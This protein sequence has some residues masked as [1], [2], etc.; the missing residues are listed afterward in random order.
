MPLIKGTGPLRAAGSNRDHGLESTVARGHVMAALFGDEDKSHCFGRYRLR[1]LLGRGAHGQVFEAFDPEL[2]RRVA[3]KIVRGDDADDADQLRAGRI[4]EAR[5]LARLDH[6][7]V[8]EVYDVGVQDG[9]VF[10]VMELVDGDDL[11]RF[12][13]ATRP[14]LA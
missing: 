2:D 3:I 10:V 12:V 11:A 7:N 8:V 4:R 14:S 1:R 13:T 5:V 9:A 6:P